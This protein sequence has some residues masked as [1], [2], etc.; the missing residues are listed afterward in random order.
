VGFQAFAFLV[1]LLLLPI[2]VCLI[3]VLNSDQPF[4]LPLH[5][6]Q[7]LF[8]LADLLL[9]H[10]AFPMS[11]TKTHFDTGGPRIFNSKQGLIREYNRF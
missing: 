5:K 11:V 2:V 1:Y 4:V 6:H 3:L 7:H 8:H 10:S 9:Q